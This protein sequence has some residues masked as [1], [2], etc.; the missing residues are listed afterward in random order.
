MDQVM[1]TPTIIPTAAPFRLSSIMAPLIAIIVGVF[2]VVLDSTAVNVALPKLVIDFNSTLSTLQWTVTGY[3]L[4]QAAVIP[5]AGWLSDRYGAKPLFIA[6]VILFTAGSA[7]CSTATSANMLI[8]FRVLQGL[9]GGFVLPVAMSFTY[10]LSPPEKT[11]V[12]MGMMGVPILFAPAIGPVLAGWLVE[13]QSWR[14]IFLINLPVGVIGVLLALRSLPV[15]ARQAVATLDVMGAILG[16]L[17]FASLSYGI[18]QGSSSWTSSQTIGGIAI[19]L[20][21]LIGF[22]IVEMRVAN[23][24]LQLNVFQSLDFDLGIVTQWVGQFAL[25]GGI[26]L[27]PLFLQQVRGYGAFDTGIALLP[28]ALASAVFMPIGGVLFDRIGARPLV[29]A[30]CSLM[31]GASLMLTHLTIATQRQDLIVPLAMYGMGMGLM[32]MPLNTHLINA[33]SRSLVSRVTALTNALQQVVNSLTIAALA[34]ILTSQAKF[35]IKATTA[36]LNV[37]GAQLAAKVKATLTAQAA[38]LAAQAK[39]S[40]SVQAA[41]L[42][43]RAKAAQIAAAHTQHLTAAQIAKEAQAAQASIKAQLAHAAQTAQVAISNQ[44]HHAALVQAA[45]AKTQMAQIAKVAVARGL[46]NGFTDTVH[47]MVGMGI[48]GTLLGFTLRRLTRVVAEGEE[49]EPAAMFV[50]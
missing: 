9:G 34:T 7:L 20:V 24:L 8:A 32:M 44:M 36:G 22:I 14:W 37:Q 13:Y 47:V 4:A 50:A 28:Q 29:V 30:G 39:S 46:A 18:S 12:V 49:A 2:M 1:T 48:V 19:G 40:L 31:V 10:R 38:Q 11:G 3:A 45:A 27:I 43:A 23:P 21:S 33:A 41:H 15:L 26:F 25:F 35:H 6:S 17:A 42:A 5:L 16:P